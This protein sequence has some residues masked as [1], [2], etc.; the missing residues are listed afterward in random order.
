MTDARRNGQG[1][2]EGSVMELRQRLQIHAKTTVYAVVLTQIVAGIA[3]SAMFAVGG[4]S[5]ASYSVLTG[6]LCGA[7][8][9]FYLAL[10]MFSMS[11]D[12]SAQQM[13]RAIYVGESLKIVLVTA[14]LVVAIA[15]LDVSMPYLL[16]GYLGT[17]VVQWF[18]L[19]M[20]N[21]DGLK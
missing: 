10:K 11:V 12:S 3:L 5:R 4:D 8:P 18:A 17:V 16:G 14:L 6:T 19:L 21:S 13:L 7:L 9:N 1:I 2:A 20:P 15:R